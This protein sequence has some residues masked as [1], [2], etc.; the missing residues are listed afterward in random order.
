[1]HLRNFYFVLSLTSSFIVLWSDDMYDVIQFFYTYLSMLHCLVYG[2][3]WRKFHTLLKRKCI[4]L[5]LTV[6]LCRCLLTLFVRRVFLFFTSNVY[7][8]VYLLSI[9]LSS[10]LSICDSWVLKCTMVIVFIFISTFVSS[11]ICFMKMSVSL[12]LIIIISS[13]WVVPLTNM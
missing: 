6:T 2:L 11:G 7:L 1:M 12:L 9:C 4:L 13:C 3:F 5:S 8:V 10:Y